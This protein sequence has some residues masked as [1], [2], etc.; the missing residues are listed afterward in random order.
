MSRS[1]RLTGVRQNNLKNISVEFPSRKLTV[2]TGLSGSGKSSLAFDTLYAEGQRRYIESLSTYTR[3]FLEKMPKPDLDSI[4]NIPPAIALEQ[5]N[6]VVNSRSTVGTQTEIVDYLRLLFAKIGRT[7]CVNCGGLVQKLDSQSILDWAAQWLPGRKAL[8]L[9]PPF[10]GTPQPEAKSKAKSKSKKKTTAQKKTS[11]KKS[12]APTQQSLFQIIREQGY[13]RILVRSQKGQSEVFDLEDA[14]SLDFSK[15]E[16]FIVVDRLRISGDIDTDTRGRLLDSIDQALAIGRGQIIFFDMGETEK[17]EQNWKAFD[18]RFSCTQC[19][20]EHRI[21][22]P[23]LF[24]FNSPIGACGKCS[25]FGFTLDLD[26]SLVV[27]DPSKT[28]K[29]GAIDPFSKPSLSEWQKDLFRFAER[30]G[31]SVGK[32]YRDLTGTEKKLLWYGDPNDSTFPGIIACFEE[33]KRWKY[34]IHI[35]VFIRR[36]QTQTLCSECQGARLKPEALAVKVGEKSI[37]DALSSSVRDSLQWIRGISLTPNEKK[38]SQEVFFQ[39]ERRLAFLEE[40][41]VGYLTLSRLAKTLSGG[42]FQRINLATQLG[43]GLCGTLYVLD[44]PSIGLHAADTARLIR[45]LERLR[46]QGNSVVVVEHDLD[47]M[48]S[49]DWLVELGPGAGKRG[50]ELLTQGTAQDLIQTAGSLT[51]KYLSGAFRVVRDRGQRPPAKRFLKLLGCREHNLKNINVDFPLDRLVI[52]TGVS[53]SG[54]ST[55][56]HKTLYNSLSRLFYRSNEPAGRFERLYG[57]EQL[58]GV[59]LLDQTPIGKSSRSNP[60]TY[61]KAWDEIRRI[62]ANQVLSLRRGYT[63]QYFSFNVEGGRCPVCKGEGEITLDMHFMAEVRLPCEECNGK[64]FKKNVLEVSYRGKDVNQLL[65]TT[66]DEAYELFRDNP[67]LVRKLGILR[68]VGLG[69]LQLGQSATT[70]SGGE[71]QRL[72]IAATLDDKTSANLLYI[73]DEPTTGLHLE[74]VKKLM[75][76]IQDLVDAKHSVIMIEHHLDVIAQADWVLDLG[77]SGGTEGGNLIA[78]GTPADL[79]KDP[80]S[81]TGSILKAQNYF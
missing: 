14:P 10:Q 27:P 3:Q 9:A 44:E 4:E 15:Q 21:P 69:Y 32:R 56:V 18:N 37:S 2:V 24:S 12:A 54:K 61:L 17:P 43:N 66:I 47:V 77:P 35:R 23:H 63:P 52:V 53:G 42:E 48:K 39:V 78:A 64:R 19:G 31:I 51:G 59:V 11:S 72:K 16:V 67:I 70:L 60:A 49:A 38:I 45:V 1:I 29:N 46:D 33:L 68:D 80:D 6:H 75:V 81:V 13:Q 7:S 8:I 62:F 40:V 71:S 55:L 79:A 25:G 58:G 30:Q 34:K 65:H 57:A 26:E 74:D 76:V 41:G 20:R 73:F 36:Y 5:K 50:G 22:E 28:L